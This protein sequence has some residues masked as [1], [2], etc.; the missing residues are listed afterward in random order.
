[1]Q[2]FEASMRTEMI[3]G[4]V[5]AWRLALSMHVARN[6]W[7]TFLHKNRHFLVITNMFAHTKICT[8]WLAARPAFTSNDWDSSCESSGVRRLQ[9]TRSHAVSKMHASRPFQLKAVLR[10]TLQ[11]SDCEPMLYSPRRLEGSF[12]SGVHFQRSPSCSSQFQVC[13]RFVI[14]AVCEGG[15]DVAV[16]RKHGA[17]ILVATPVAIGVAMR[18]SGFRRPPP[19]PQYQQI[20]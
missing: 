2:T 1:M 20:F 16:P 12:Q 18:V 3:R 10:P 15:Q 19:P 7:W 14:R 6:S 13:L 17:T 9:F 11:S 8:E 4:R 5:C